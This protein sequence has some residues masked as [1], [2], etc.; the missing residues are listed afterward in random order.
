MRSQFS[1]PVRV[2]L[3]KAGNVAHAV[4][5]P[6]RAA[7]ILLSEWP[8]TWSGR[9]IET[10]KAVLEAMVR[11]HDHAAMAPGMRMNDLDP[12]FA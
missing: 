8:T 12:M 1:S 6:M 4:T 2:S 3:G 10:R 5:T 9:H 11:A 7:E